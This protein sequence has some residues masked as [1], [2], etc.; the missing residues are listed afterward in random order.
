MLIQNH[1][2]NRLSYGVL[3]LPATH[4]PT[5]VNVVVI[6]DATVPIVELCANVMFTRI[7][8]LADSEAASLREF[9]WL[10]FR[11]EEVL[12]LQHVLLLD[13]GAVEPYSRVARL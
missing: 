12:G 1:G 6:W 11:G 8:D 5:N 7:H 9:F 2:W 10:G 13:L 3:L 4:P